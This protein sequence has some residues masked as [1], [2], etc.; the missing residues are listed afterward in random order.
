MPKVSLVTK[1][2]Y[3]TVTAGRRAAF[4]MASTPPQPARVSLRDVA[5]TVGVSHVTVSLALRG[6]TRVSATRR[7][8]IRAAAEQLGYRPDPMLSSLASYRRNKSAV[9]ISATVG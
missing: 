4:L 2:D 1:S 8:E 9:P 7:T 5:K 6:D 3:A